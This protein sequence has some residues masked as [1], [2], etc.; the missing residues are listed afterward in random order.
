MTTLL[1]PVLQ[2]DCDL[3]IIGGGINGV[4]IARDAAG[5]GLSVILCEQHDLAQHTSSASTKLIHGGLRYLEQYEFGLVR[6]ALQERERLL[7]IAPHIVAPLR[8]VMPHDSGQRPAWLI[9]AGLFLYDHLARR[10]LLPPSHAIALHSHIAGQDLQTAYRKGFVYSDGWVDDARLVVLNALDA[11]ERGATIM[12]ATRC[13]GAQR[14]GL[15][16]QAS[17]ESGQ[18]GRIEVSARAIVNAAGPWV[19]QTAAGLSGRKSNHGMRLVKGSH[20]VLPRLF[21]HDYAYLFQNPDRRIIFA[22]PFQRDFTLIGTTDLEYQGDPSQVTI[23]AAEVSYLCAMVNR[24]FK[25]Q[26]GPQDVVWSYSGVRPLLDDSAQKA[27]E[28]T[29]GYQLEC[30]AADGAA[31]LLNIWGG[32]IT[33]YRKLAEEALALLLPRLGLPATL[34]TECWTAGTPLPGGDLQQPGALITRYDFDAFQQ[35]L[36]S[37]YPWLPDEL[38]RRYAHSYGSRTGRML[39]GAQQMADL[40][41]QLV[42]GLFEREAAYLCEFEWA[43]SVDDLL[44]RRTKLGLTSQPQHRARLQQ[45][46]DQRRDQRQDQPLA[47]S[48]G[49]PI[50][51]F[52]E[53]CG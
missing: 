21:E 44:W 23:D 3:L 25:R 49:H 30:D 32:K 6:K 18:S 42:P 8:F 20:I 34:K 31:P 38:T 22:I 16:W 17:L 51:Q 26:I 41:E 9:R 19:A 48:A 27:A 43:R 45:W 35:Q 37:R 28:I 47:G 12:T 13:V 10:D 53:K 5:R 46:L 4:G 15:R 52:V 14:V 40:G 7:R 2:R 50:A 36:A 33:T 24:Y 1:E 11:S 29:R 39:A